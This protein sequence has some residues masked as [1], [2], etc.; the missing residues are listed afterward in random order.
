MFPGDFRRDGFGSCKVSVLERWT[1]G[2]RAAGRG[3]APGIVEIARP[4]L[5]DAGKRLPAG[6][7]N[8]LP[9]VVK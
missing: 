3:C 9:P 7:P 1:V 5:Y 4:F 2:D 6:I 8:V